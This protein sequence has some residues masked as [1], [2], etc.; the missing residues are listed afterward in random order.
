LQEILPQSILT[1]NFSAFSR[2]AF[3]PIIINNP[4]ESTVIKFIDEMVR[5]KS[6]CG[7]FSLI[8]PTFGCYKISARTFVSWF[9]S[10]NDFTLH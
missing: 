5:F 10:D 4:T 3:Y 1:W 7:N 8:T 2:R 6:R 9:D